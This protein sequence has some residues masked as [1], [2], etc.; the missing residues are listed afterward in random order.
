[1]SLGPK[2][3]RQGLFLGFLTVRIAHDLDRARQHYDE[4]FASVGLDPRTFDPDLYWVHYIDYALILHR[5]GE[6]DAAADL[7]GQIQAHFD[8]QI[9]DGIEVAYSGDHLQFLYAKLQGALDDAPGVVAALQRALRE[10]H[11]CV[12]CLG[13]PHFDT[14]RDDPGF[15]A[16][17]HDYEAAV[18]ADRHRLA[19]AG[20]LLTPAEVTRLEA[21]DFDPFAR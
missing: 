16:V 9:S 17:L 18:A 19:D 8:R 11:R 1:M 7:A 14:V 15:V 12:V 6:V 10:G 5:A 13:F 3:S 21:L 20:M 2:Q 4:G